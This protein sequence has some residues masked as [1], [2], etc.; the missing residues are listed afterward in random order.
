MVADD[1]SDCTT[2]DK[3]A[4]PGGAVPT[5]RNLRFCAMAL[6]VAK[7]SETISPMITRQVQLIRLLFFFEFIFLFL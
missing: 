5:L 6:E 2:D 1:L 3:N 4:P 7:L